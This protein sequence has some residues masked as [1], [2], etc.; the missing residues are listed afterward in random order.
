MGEILPELIVE[1]ASV[2]PL[3]GVLVYFS[4]SFSLIAALVCGGG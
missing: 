3:A 1:V 4:L 2:D